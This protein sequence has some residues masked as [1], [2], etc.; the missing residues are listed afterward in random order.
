MVNRDKEF[1]KKYLKERGFP[2]KPSSYNW[3]YEEVLELM[4]YA[5]E[6]ERMEEIT[7]GRC[8]K[9]LLFHEDNRHKLM[10]CPNCKFVN[11]IV[12]TLF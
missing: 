8:S 5:H 12:G 1:I 3:R 10:V 2:H 9:T 7:C 11:Q 6:S 4:K